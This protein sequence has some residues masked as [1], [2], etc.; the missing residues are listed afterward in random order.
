MTIIAADLPAIVF[1]KVGRHAGEDFEEILARKREEYER[2]GMIFWG[3]GGGTMHP[4]QRV[5]PFARMK[6]EEGSGLVLVMKSI[7][8]RHPDTSVF[9]REY[10]KDGVNWQSIPEGVRVRGSRYALVLD[11]VLPGDLEIDFAQYRVGVGPSA[12]RVASDYVQG[13]VDKACL[14]RADSPPPGSEPRIIKT[15]FMAKLKEPY[16]VVLR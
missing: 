6:I 5:Q 4:I 3:Y 16:A 1:M 15:E 2:A 10:S 8:S 13:R 11:E 7:I 9:A 14:E 12:G